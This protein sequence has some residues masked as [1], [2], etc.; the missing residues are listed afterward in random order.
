MNPKIV[1]I[2]AKVFA[3]VLGALGA[4]AA[5]NGINKRKKK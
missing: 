1:E 3:A 2:A 5:K 4:L